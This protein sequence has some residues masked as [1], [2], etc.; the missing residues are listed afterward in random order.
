MPSMRLRELLE[1][2]AGIICRQRASF[3]ANE[4][5]FVATQRL[6]CEFD[7]NIVGKDVSQADI[8]DFRVPGHPG[9]RASADD[10]RNASKPT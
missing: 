3:E 5:H 7:A 8:D 6:L 4:E 9:P 2:R 10:I 1:N